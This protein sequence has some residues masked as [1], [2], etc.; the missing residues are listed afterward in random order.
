METISALQGLLG[1]AVVTTFIGYR[2]V[3]RRHMPLFESWFQLPIR[4]D[5]DTRL[6][7]AATLFGIGWG[8]TGYCP[9]TDGRLAGGAELA[10]G[11]VLVAMVAGWWLARRCSSAH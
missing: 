3:W 10:A 9:G 7:G 11:A 6:L 4:R 8:L 2:L 5:L 1:G